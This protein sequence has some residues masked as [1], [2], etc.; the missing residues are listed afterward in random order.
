MLIISVNFIVMKVVKVLF[1]FLVLLS[2]WLESKAQGPIPPPPEVWI[3]EVMYNPPESGIDSLEFVEL[4]SYYALFQLDG[5]KFDSGIDYEFPAGARA[6]SNG[7]VIVARDSVAFYN[8]FGISAY[9]WGGESLLN[10]GETISIESP[11]QLPDTVTYTNSTPWPDA[12]GNGHSISLCGNTTYFANH[13]PSYWQASQNNTGVVVNGITIFAD[14]GQPGNCATVGLSNQLD[15]ETLLIYPNPTNSSFT[16]LFPELM[17]DAIFSMHDPMGS[18][19][20]Y[21][22][23]TKGSSKLDKHMVLAPGIYLL[24]LET[25]EDHQAQYLV[26]TE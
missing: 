9:D 19:I 8:A 13:D 23:V 7:Y 14:P 17:D 20:H 18:L 4:R 11:Y 2:V 6:D 21:E 24:K 1:A 26:V 5:F 10:S 15:T 12:D 25:D 16:L 3:T 22:A